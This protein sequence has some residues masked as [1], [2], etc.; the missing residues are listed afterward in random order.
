MGAQFLGKAGLVHDES[1]FGAMGVQLELDDRV[2]SV[3][4]IADAPRLDD[5]LIG[6]K[7]DVAPCDDPA[8]ARE[9]APC[10]ATDLGRCATRE[11]TELSRIEQGFID[12]LRGCL[13]DNLLMYRFR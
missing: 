2:H 1:G 10:I 3:R 11:F 7:L 4:P 13:E 12:E 5:A 8:E 6:Q 9:S